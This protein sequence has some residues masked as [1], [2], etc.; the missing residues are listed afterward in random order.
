[1]TYREGFKTGAD[2][3][4]TPRGDLI[5]DAESILNLWRKQFSSLLNG[6]QSVTPGDG[7]PDSPIED[8]GINASLLGFMTRTA[9]VRLKDQQNRLASVDHRP[10]Y[11]NPNTR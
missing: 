3:C 5:T 11:S 2:Y 9:I 6:G 8:D 1:M 10:S 7:E 4:R